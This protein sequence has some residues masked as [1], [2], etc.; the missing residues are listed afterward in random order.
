MM[1]ES[2]ILSSSQIIFIRLL[3]TSAQSWCA[4]SPATTV[5]WVLNGAEFELALILVPDEK[6]KSVSAE[7]ATCNLQEREEFEGLHFLAQVN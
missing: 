6:Q 1:G 7:N 5:Q 4:F 2:E 3:S